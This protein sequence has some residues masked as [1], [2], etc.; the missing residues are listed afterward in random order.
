[1]GA[2]VGVFAIK[3]K[4]FDEEAVQNLQDILKYDHSRRAFVRFMHSKDLD[5]L[6]NF[7]YE[8]EALL[9]MSELEVYAVILEKAEGICSNYIGQIAQRAPSYK[10]SYPFVN[11]ERGTLADISMSLNI[12]LVEAKTYMASYIFEYSESAYIE[13]S[14]VGEVL[15]DTSTPRSEQATKSPRGSFVS[16]K[17]G[18][19]PSSPQAAG[20]KG[21]KIGF[22]PPRLMSSIISGR[23]P[24]LKMSTDALDETPISLTASSSISAPGSPYTSRKSLVVSTLPDKFPKVLVI[25]DSESSVKVV[26][27]MF[28]AAGHFV[29]DTAGNG[30]VGLDLFKSAMHSIVVVDVYMPVLGGIDTIRRIRDHQ[31]DVSHNGGSVVT[32]VE[33]TGAHPPDANLASGRRSRGPSFGEQQQVI[34][35]A[36]S[37]HSS[38]ELVEDVTRAGAD[39]FLEKPFTIEGLAGIVTRTVNISPR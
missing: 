25:D 5:P 24:L 27:R 11:T 12:L 7:S 35:I 21:A 36:V 8:L 13:E 15:M 32:E 22:S 17:G 34:I 19:S 6:V 39:G 38:P 4:I 3:G 37:A 10:F 30:A 18:Q 33:T 16:S 26:K 14:M 1:M 20:G 23:Q 28:Q 9:A 29:V 2:T 31:D